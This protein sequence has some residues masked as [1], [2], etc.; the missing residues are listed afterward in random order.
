VKKLLP[1]KA[2]LKLYITAL[3]LSMPSFLFSQENKKIELLN[4]NSLEFDKSKS[5]AKRLIGDVGLKH[6]GMYMFC[7]SAY[8]YSEENKLE[9][10]GNVRLKPDAG[11]NIYGDTLYYDG[12][13]KYAK[14]RGV[15]KMI[16]KET[17]LT[18]KYLDYNQKTD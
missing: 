1:E 17:Q 9:A 10:Y 15:V 2:Y 18:T 4:A 6:D 12:K 13:T 8:L 3:L 11:T 5:N 7:D 14:L 16:D